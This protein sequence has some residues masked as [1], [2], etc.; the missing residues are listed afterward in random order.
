VRGVSL[1]ETG[2]SGFTYWVVTDSPEPHVL[3]LPPPG[4]RIAGPADVAR[5]G[6]IMQ[7]LSTAG[8]PVPRVIA[9]SDEA[10]VDGRPFILLE[11]VDGERIE[12]I[13]GSVPDQK[14]AGSA[15]EVLRRL[16]E[17]PVPDTGIGG[18][19]PVPLEDELGR[20]RRL[21]ERAPEELTGMAPHVVARLSQR[22]PAQAAPTLV[23]GDYHYGNLLFKNGEVAGVLDWEIAALGQPLV[24]VA[25]LVLVADAGRR[26]LGVPGGTPVETSLEFVVQTYGAEP[27]AIRWYLALAYFKLAAIF[28]YNLMLHRRGKRHD[29]HNE[30]RAREVVTYLEAALDVLE[31]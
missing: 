3:R 7:A 30:A 27:K 6:R 25:S 28:G 15:V 22:V 9:M 4:A 12:V 1:I 8:M 11:K 20:W 5:Q 31:A 21:I 29:P 14:L 26:G 24:D 17:V 18:E 2:H 19:T 10:M 16:H 23:H 13:K